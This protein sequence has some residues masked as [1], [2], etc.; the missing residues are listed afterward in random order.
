MF[1]FLKLYQFLLKNEIELMIACACTDLPFIIILLVEVIFTL[2][3]I[4][5]QPIL[6]LSYSAAVIITID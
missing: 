2:T 1:F 5:F 3:N 4:I 6:S